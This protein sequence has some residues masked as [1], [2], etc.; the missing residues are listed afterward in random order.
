MRAQE[1]LALK[2]NTSCLSD[3]RSA[4]AGEGEGRGSEGGK[5]ECWKK[6]GYSIYLLQVRLDRAGLRDLGLG[7]QY[8]EGQKKG[9]SASGIIGHAIN[10]NVRCISYFSL[11]LHCTRLVPRR[12]ILDL[13]IYI[14]IF[15]SSFTL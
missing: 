13:Y 3:Q 6:R 10:L 8:M 7:V 5:A 9:S 11:P 12:Y 2:T 14:E 1:S 4:E 15:L